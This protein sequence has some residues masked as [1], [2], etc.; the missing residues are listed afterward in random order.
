VQGRRRRWKVRSRLYVEDS[1]CRVEVKTKDGRG[2]TDKAAITVH[3]DAYGRLDAASRSFVR[4]ASAQH[5]LRLDV[6]DLLPV[7]EVIYQRVTLAD[8]VAGTR[9]TID[10]GLSCIGANGVV[11]LDPAV[12]L[13]E[14]KGGTRPAVADRLLWQLGVRPRS[15]SKYV[16]AGS[17]LTAGVA[18]NDIRP[19]LG[20]SVHVARRSTTTVEDRSPGAG[21]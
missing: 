16:T 15:F 17:L 6:R 7:V 14:T 11:W 20:R 2:L 1:L 12:L 9:L 19:L 21:R 10:S 3:A 13:V 8:L 18:D 4:A 5:R